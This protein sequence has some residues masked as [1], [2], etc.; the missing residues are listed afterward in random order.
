MD[1]LLTLLA[2][3]T[4]ALRER[5]A[6]LRERP[7]AGYSTETALITALLVALGL[8]ALAVISAKVVAKV[9]SID[10]Q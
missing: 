7:D 6:A 10:L 1:P 4:S 3:V 8:T 9:R 2:T 5:L